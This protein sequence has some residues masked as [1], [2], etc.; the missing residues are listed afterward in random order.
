[1]SITSVR[2][3]D[4]LNESLKILAEKKQRSKSWL[5]NEALAEY[6]INDELKSQKWLDT[7][8]GLESIRKGDVIDGEEVFAWMQSWGTDDELAPPQVKSKKVKK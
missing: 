5:I 1:M 2:I 6:I 3:K 7:L 4:D 8:E